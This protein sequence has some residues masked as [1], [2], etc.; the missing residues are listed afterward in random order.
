MSKGWH[1]DRMEHGLASKGIETTS[2]KKDDFFGEPIYSYSSEQAEEDGMLI[3][4]GKLRPEW[5]KGL[6][7]YITVG[8]M[9]KGYFEPD[10]KVRLVNVVDILNQANQIVRRKSEGFKKFDT[11]FSGKIELPSGQ[12]QEIFIEQNETGKFTILLPEEH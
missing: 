2:K 5:K 7:N 11:F 3:N 1:N 6:F 10:G 12:Q 8:L 9:E 4:V